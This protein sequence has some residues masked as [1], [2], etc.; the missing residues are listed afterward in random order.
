MFQRPE[1]P[2]A[3]LNEE[4]PVYKRETEAKGDQRKVETSPNNDHESNSAA[5]PSPEPWQE[6]HVICNIEE[7]PLTTVTENQIAQL[8]QFILRW[9][10]TS[11]ANQDLRTNQDL[12]RESLIEMREQ[13][14]IRE[15]KCD[16][17]NYLNR[18]G[19]HRRNI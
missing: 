3:K 9:G 1:E 14:T 18:R 11:L 2:T 6:A 19:L 4:F 8:R 16:L 5:T 12:F 17:L 15:F 10:K 13:R 7:N